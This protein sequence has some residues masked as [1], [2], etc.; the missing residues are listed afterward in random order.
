MPLATLDDVNQHLPTDKISVEEGDELDQYQLDVERI[1]KG[2]LS[3]TYE[4][5]TLAGWSDPTVSPTHAKYVP[6]L[7]R[8]IAGRFI[9]SFFYAKR[10]SEETTEVAPYAQKLYDEAW[11]L[12]RKIISGDVVLYDETDEVAET[13]ARL[14]DDDFFPRDPIETPPRFTVDQRF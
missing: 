10:F 8:S 2:A 4:P 13:G 1:I 12:L 9:A 5:T 14:T 11:D 6:G 7:I 3:N